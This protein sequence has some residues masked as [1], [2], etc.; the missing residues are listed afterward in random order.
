[1]LEASSVRATLS[2][3]AVHI[4]SQTWP[5]P[6]YRRT[7]QVHRRVKRLT[8]QAQK[9]WKRA[10]STYEG[11]HATRSSPAK[12][13]TGDGGE[14]TVWQRRYLSTLATSGGHCVCNIASGGRSAIHT[15]SG[16]ELS[17]DTREP[18]QSSIHPVQDVPIAL[19]IAVTT[20]HSSRGSSL[21][22]LDPTSA[23]LLRSCRDSGMK[24]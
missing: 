9:P 2:L 12:A 16:K 3:N 8:S 10:Q 4:R 6:A 18:M 13:L 17:I 19:M 1:M 22:R 24:S 14:S 7:L 5:G 21:M 20:Y 15:S 11:T 23:C